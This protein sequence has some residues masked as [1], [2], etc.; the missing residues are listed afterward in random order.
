MTTGPLVS[1]DFASSEVPVSEEIHAR[2][3]TELRGRNVSQTVKGR[4]REGCG[5]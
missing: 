5:G 1:A 4:S 3:P 2:R